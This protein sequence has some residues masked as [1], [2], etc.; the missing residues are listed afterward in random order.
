MVAG[1]RLLIVVVVMGCCYPSCAQIQQTGAT[2]RYVIAYRTEV[3]ATSGKKTGV[4]EQVTD[5]NIVV[6]NDFNGY[7][8]I[9]V[10]TIKVVRIKFR[11]DM[12]TYTVQDFYDIDKLDKTREGFIDLNSPR[13][14]RYLNSSEAEQVIGNVFFNAVGILGTKGVN[15][16]RKGL[17]GTITKF[18]INNSPEKYERAKPELQ[19]YALQYQLSPEYEVYLRDALAPTSGMPGK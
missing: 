6:R 11:P 1:L 2:E 13:N 19:L 9:P 7:D 12:A 14:Q 8:Y 15:K 3:T 16:L 10:R 5:S 18:R 4:L 17:A